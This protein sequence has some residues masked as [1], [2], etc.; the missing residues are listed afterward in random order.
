MKEI[1]AGILK[2]IKIVLIVLAVISAISLIVSRVF[3]F[4]STSSFDYIY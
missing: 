3:E 2:Y 4:K 1:L